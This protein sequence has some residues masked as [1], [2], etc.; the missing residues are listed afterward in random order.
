MGL[1]GVEQV[2]LPLRLV[3]VAQQQVIDAALGIAGEPGAGVEQLYPDGDLEATEDGGDQIHIQAPWLAAVIQPFQ[4]GFQ[5]AA[6]DQLSGRQPA[7]QQ[8]AEHEQASQ[9]TSPEHSGR[10]HDPRGIVTGRYLT[11]DDPGWQTL[12]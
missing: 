12:K 1:F 5:D 4:R 2:G 3:G 8:Q 6:N 7:G 10:V 11:R 9:I